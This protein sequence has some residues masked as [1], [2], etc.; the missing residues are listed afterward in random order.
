MENSDKINSKTQFQ[1]PQGGFS[2]LQNPKLLPNILES[3]RIVGVWQN[4]K[5]T[6]T[7]IGVLKNRI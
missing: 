2:P 7:K 5:Q 6:I 4:P 1:P 3:I